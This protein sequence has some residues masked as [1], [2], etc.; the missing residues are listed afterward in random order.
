[1]SNYGKARPTATANFHKAAGNWA[2]NVSRILRKGDMSPRGGS[3][4]TSKEALRVRSGEVGRCTVVADFDLHSLA[5][6]QIEQAAAILTRAGYTV[7]RSDADRD[8]T[9]IPRLVVTRV[10][11]DVADHWKRRKDP[12][13]RTFY[14]SQRW[15]AWTIDVTDD[16]FVT[17]QGKTVH[18]EP[19]A[20]LYE[21]TAFV[22]EH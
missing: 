15:P 5:V 13:R 7:E 11:A 4:P 1:M 20:T 14:Q 9:P 6:T 10:A 8:G 12:M 19:F 22:E 21:A 2:G 3:D 16:G 17:R 18:G